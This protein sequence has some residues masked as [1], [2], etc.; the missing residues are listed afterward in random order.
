MYIDKLADINK[1]N[2]THHRT[3]KMKLVDVKS[4]TYI[5]F[6][7]EKIDKDPQFKVCDHVRMSKY[8]NI[9]A[10]GHGRNCSDVFIIKK[11]W[12][13]CVVKMLLLVILTMKKLL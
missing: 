1:Y 3:I 2:N 11:S 4:I 12:K 13:Y 7:Q 10:K 9:I 5:D 6:G 8:K